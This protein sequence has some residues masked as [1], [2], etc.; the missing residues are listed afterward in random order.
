[1][2]AQGTRTT[3]REAGIGAG[4]RGPGPVF[5]LGNGISVI[6]PTKA[7]TDFIERRLEEIRSR[8]L[9][10][11]LKVV[12]GEQDATVVLNG[13]EVLNLSSNNYLGLANHPALKEAAREALDRWGCGS[14]A[15]RLISGN[16]TA[17]EEL[18]QRIARFKGTEAALV[19]NSGYQANVG[20]IATLAEKDDVVLSDELNHASVIDGCRLSRAAVSVYRH[21]DM[22]HLESL[23]KAA[24]AGARKLIVTESVF[25]M[26]GDVAP[27]REMVELAERHGA[28]VMVDEAH[29]TGVRGPNGAGVVA[30]LGLGDRVL[31]QMGTLGKALGAFGAYVAGSARLRELL[32]NRARSFIFTTSLPPVVMAM[33]AASVELV[34]KEPARRCALQRN[35]AKLRD[36]LQQ[37]GCTVAG[38]TQIIPVIVGEEQPCMDLAARLLESGFYVQGIRPPTVPPGTS[39]LRVT[40]MAT[41]TA[42]QMEQAVDAFA[43]ARNG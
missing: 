18:E 9:Y 43:Q 22:E 32:I 21:C 33:A 25:S 4:S 24:P 8:N 34:E 26:D 28:M 40:T 38:S 29:A 11:Q 10:R 27:L 42:E 39:R 17:H 30:E 14:G 36:G 23:L 41:H 19:F 37:V 1:M 3:A 16:M 7:M 12:D 35:T 13:R 5:W 2:T 6:Y 15:S 31:V 20:I